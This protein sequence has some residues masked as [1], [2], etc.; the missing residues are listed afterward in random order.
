MIWKNLKRALI[1]WL[2][3]YCERIIWFKNI[4]SVKCHRN[5]K[6]LLSIQL[7]FK[8]LRY[9]EWMNKKRVLL[10]NFYR[11]PSGRGGGQWV[12][13]RSDSLLIS[14]FPASS[15]R[16]KKHW[17]APRNRPAISENVN[18]VNHFRTCN[19]IS[20]LMMLL[21]KYTKNYWW[22]ARVIFALQIPFAV[23]CHHWQ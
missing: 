13:W 7:F 6:N 15:W 8:K 1:Y 9:Y 3:D 23:R 11:F 17:A 20:L 18:N 16:G 4:Y 22:R 21:G 12:Q 5:K 2:N 10:N 19:K 14:V